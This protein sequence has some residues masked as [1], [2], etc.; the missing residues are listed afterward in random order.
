MESLIDMKYRLMLIEHYLE[1]AQHIPFYNGYPKWRFRCPFCGSL[2]SKEYKKKARKGSLLWD[3]RQNS[4]I[5]YCAKKGTSECRNSKNLYYFIRTLNPALAEEYRRER[6]HSVT[7]GKGRNCK[8]PKSI[9][10]ISTASKFKKYGEQ[11][12]NT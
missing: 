5:F 8:M 3:V 10:G 11:N 12:E 7:V 4:W 6:Y 9:T 1:G 2:S